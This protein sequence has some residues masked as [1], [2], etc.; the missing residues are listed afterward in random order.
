MNKLS[1]IQASYLAGFIDADGS[2]L[3]QI[4]SREDYVLK[5]QIRVSVLCIQKRN[6]MHHLKDFQSEIGKGSIRDRGD[7][8]A[9]FAIVGHKNVSEL[10]QQIQPY[11]RNKK[12]QANCILRICEQLNQIKN[13]PQKFLELCVLADHVAALNDSRN[14]TNTTETVKKVLTDLGLIEN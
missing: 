8:I 3:A 10:L 14:R 11:L 5:F 9:E 13:N 4:V 2:I 7:G 1:I 12:K 6:R